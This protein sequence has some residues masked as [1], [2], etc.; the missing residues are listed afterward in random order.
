MIVSCITTFYNELSSLVRHI[1]K[2]NVR[3]IGEDIN[4]QI[5]EDENNKFGLHK[6]PNIKREHQIDFSLENSLSCLNDK[7][8]TRYDKLWAY[9]NLN[10][11]KIQLDCL[12]INKR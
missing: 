6:S 3:I 11:T 7:F 2:H 4:V 5:R 9:N 12:L 1:L 8:H 10:N